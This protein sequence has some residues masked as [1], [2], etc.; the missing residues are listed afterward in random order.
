MKKAIA[1]VLS[2]VS[3][4]TYAATTV[5]VQLINPTG[6]SSGQAVV[7]TGASS[8]P[9]W[10]GVGLN[11]IAAIAANTILANATSSSASP[12][13]FSMPS[14]STSSSALNYTTNTGIGCNTSINAAQ[15]LGA[16]WASPPAAGYGSAT[17][18]PVA[19]TI[20]SANS[21]SAVT[22][23]N[24]AAS[25]A[26]LSLVSASNTANGVTVTLTGNGVTTP[27]KSIRVLSGNL[28]VVNNANSSSILTLT[29]AGAL[30]VNSS[31]TPT[32]PGGIIGN[33]TG[34]NVSAGSVG[35]PS[36]SAP[37]ATSLTSATTMNVG[38][39][40]LTAGDWD[41]SGSYIYTPAGSTTGTSI[42][43]GLN[44]TSA[45]F[46]SAGKTAVLQTSFPAGAQQVVALPPIQVNSSGSTTVYCVTNTTFS[47]STATGQ[48]YFY[49][50]RR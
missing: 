41:V 4:I 38:S 9:A 30:S 49:A 25:G 8:A 21:T 43:A 33:V 40:S 48:C 36:I 1:F 44:T 12:T 28:Q 50:R 24:T 34:S 14:C 26:T 3:A 35:E 29:D 19:A 13:A 37:A 23:T 27:A 46:G 47:V 22:I 15:L 16:T 18:A 10:G 11:G 2:F 5:P 6:S 7:S 45:A 31:V 32:Y 17:P 20:L 42:F 39:I